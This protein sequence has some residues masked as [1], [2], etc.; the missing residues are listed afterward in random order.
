[1]HQSSHELIE[2]VKKS[3]EIMKQRPGINELSIQ[4][5]LDEFNDDQ[6]EIKRYRWIIAAVVYVDRLNDYSYELLV[7]KLAN[8]TIPEH[9]CG[10]IMFLL[11]Q[12]HGISCIKVLK[13]ATQ[14]DS[15]Q[16]LLPFVYENIR[17]E[18]TINEEIIDDFLHLMHIVPLN[19][20]YRI[21]SCYAERISNNSLEQYAFSQLL[22]NRPDGADSFMPYLMESIYYKDYN[23]GDCYLNKIVHSA[24]ASDWINT[25]VAS[26]R[27]SLQK[28][29]NA[30]EDCFSLIHGFVEKD[31]L[32]GKILP[33]YIE[34]S[35]HD[36]Q[37][38]KILD[39]VI[40][41]LH[42]I[43]NDSLQI[44]LTFLNTI[45]FL[46]KTSNPIEEIR[47][48]IC[49][50]DFNKN[51][52]MIEAIEIYYSQKGMPID[53]LLKELHSIFVLNNYNIGNY[54]EF[55]TKF[56]NVLYKHSEH[57]LKIIE[58]IFCAV[59]DK[60]DASVAFVIGLLEHANLSFPSQNEQGILHFNEEMACLVIRIITAFTVHGELLFTFAFEL[61]PYIQE[62]RRNYIKTFFNEVYSSYPYTCQEMAQKYVNSPCLIQKDLAKQILA[63]WKEENNNQKKWHSVPDLWP[64]KERQVIARKVAVE[65]NQRIRKMANEKSFFAQLFNNC[66]MKYGKRSG[67]IRQL[68]HGEFGYQSSDYITKEIHMELSKIYLY[69]PIEWYMNRQEVLDERRKYIAANH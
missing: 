17:Y 19:K 5:I 3:R 65:Q 12:E 44:Q 14:N 13:T 60:N 55:F 23:L 10:Y 63:K 37:N 56:E 6:Q 69:T 15:F 67:I 43:K 18:P 16:Q 2:E 51:E 68:G 1:M 25:I 28:K 50:R 59:L 34:Y 22:E 26:L 33:C 40:R 61:I 38:C 53:E 35:L 29:T 24:D 52:Q 27:C 21:Y 62:T 49:I 41:C 8:D 31:D 39:E 20:Q 46:K 48:S 9:L 42:K 66:I 58:Y 7:Y 54:H 57:T 45:T 4:E 36:G 32:W 30:F 11:Q 47:F 64:S